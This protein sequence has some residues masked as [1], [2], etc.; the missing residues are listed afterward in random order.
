ML[1]VIYESFYILK[2]KLEVEKNVEN[3]KVNKE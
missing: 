1:V 3:R 2:Y